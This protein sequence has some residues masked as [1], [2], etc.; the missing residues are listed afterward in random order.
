MDKVENGS[1]V[2]VSYAVKLPNGEKVQD[3]QESGPITFTVGSGEVLPG[4]EQAVVGMSPGEEKTVTIPAEQAYGLY[5]DELIF[6][7]PRDNWPDDVP[8]EMGQ[9]ISLL[10]SDAPE[11]GGEAIQARVTDIEGSEITLDANHPLAGEDLI[12]TIRVEGAK[13]GRKAA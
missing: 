2:R 1:Q 5:D 11:E 12:F 10:P 4:F 9:H 6:T 7:L 3:S 8:L 13:P